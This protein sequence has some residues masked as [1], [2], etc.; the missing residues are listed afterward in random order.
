[1]YTDGYFAS[2]VDTSVRLHAK[3]KSPVYY[4]EFDYRGTNSYS[5]ILG[6]PSTDYGK[7]FVSKLMHV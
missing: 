5:N 7:L 2:G 3:K 4:F 1:M 6:D